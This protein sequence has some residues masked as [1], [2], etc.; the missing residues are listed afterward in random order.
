MAWMEQL[1][2]TKMP[3]G[4]FG[5]GDEDAARI[6]LVARLGRIDARPISPESILFQ[7]SR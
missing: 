7:A 4:N 6:E 1:Q 2:S 3:P 5:V